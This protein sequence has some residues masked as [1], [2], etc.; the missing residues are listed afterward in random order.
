M[1]VMAKPVKAPFIVAEDKIEAFKKWADQP[2]GQR[3]ID[4]LMARAS[5]FMKIPH[6]R[7]VE[8]SEE[9]DDGVR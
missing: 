2:K 3:D 6:Y 7:L 1:A 4:R 5:K 8:V 9:P